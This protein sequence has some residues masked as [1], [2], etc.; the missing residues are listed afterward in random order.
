MF[1][2]AYED[3]KWVDRTGIK[4][5]GRDIVPHS[6]RHSLGSMLEEKGVS[7][8]Y[9]QE[10]LGHSDCKSFKTTKIYFHSTEK[11]I[12]SIGK[13]TSETM[14]TDGQKNLMSNVS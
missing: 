9:I 10:L 2:L 7:I 5:N 8:R 6:A 1:F 11:T 4:L 3:K 14:E 12:Q 13:K